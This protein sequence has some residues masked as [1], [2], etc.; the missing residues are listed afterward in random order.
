[1]A[2]SSAILCH[3]SIQLATARGSSSHTAIS[4]YPTSETTNVRRV[5]RIN[6]FIVPPIL[7]TAQLLALA[8]SEH[9]DKHRPQVAIFLAVDQ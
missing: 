3:V 4:P 8:F 6:L 2:T 1:M 7:A 5:G 9:P